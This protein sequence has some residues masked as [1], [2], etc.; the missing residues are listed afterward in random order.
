MDNIERGLEY[1]A[2]DIVVLAT[3]TGELICI[4]SD[5]EVSEN[6]FGSNIEEIW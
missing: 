5:I 6:P 3:D 1:V 2:P 4:S